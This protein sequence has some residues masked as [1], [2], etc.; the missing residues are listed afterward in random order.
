MKSHFIPIISILCAV[1][2]P[3]SAFGGSIHNHLTLDILPIAMSPNN[4]GGAGFGLFY[5]RYHDWLH[6]SYTLGVEAS[7]PYSGDNR[8]TDVMPELG[9]FTEITKPFAIGA[10]VGLVTNNPGGVLGFGA[11]GLRLPALE[12]KRRSSCPS[13]SRK[14]T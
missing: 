1:V 9:F 14:S 6:S 12:P 4:P 3:S 10:R 7:I 2:I 11:L 13:F 5:D 8:R